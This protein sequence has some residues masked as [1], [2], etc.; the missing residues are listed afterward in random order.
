MDS[1]V[2][3][4]MVKMSEL[5]KSREDK[6]TA[7]SCVIYGDGSC[8]PNPGPSG[9]GVHGMDSDGHTFNAWGGLSLKSSNNRG[10]LA[11]YI[12]ILEMTL[13]YKW[14]NTVIHL[15][16][17]YVINGAMR[18]ITKWKK[19]GW[20]KSDGNVIS[21]KDLWILIDTLQS[22][23]AKAKQVID[24]K[25][26][27]AHTGVHGNEMADANADKGRLS[28]V[29]G[30]TAYFLHID[31]DIPMAEIKEVV[32]AS[33][34]KSTK[35]PGCNRLIAGK[36]LYFTTNSDMM[37]PDN[38]HIYMTNSFDD[39]TEW[40]GKLCGQLSSD[41]LHG[42]I[43]TKKAVEPL[44]VLIEYQNMITPDDFV[45]PV[46]GM[47]DRITKPV[48]WSMLNTLGYSQLVHN[49]Y[50]ILTVDK[51]PLTLYVRP[52]R[53]AYSTMDIL[54]VML[55]R[56]DTY[57][58]DK[59]ANGVEYIDITDNLYSKV[60]KVWKIHTGKGKAL[61]FFKVP[62][63]HNGKS[64]EVILTMG[65]DILPRNN[66][67]GL[68]KQAESLNVILVKYNNSSASF[69]YSVIFKTESDIA[70]YMT[71]GANLKIS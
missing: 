33:K 4:M 7:K 57:R 54:S 3:G 48:N 15:D 18:F 35:L 2:E 59:I 21:N 5:L 40:K 65:V 61:K 39:K 12:F 70:I 60:G 50:N 46:I 1:I 26:V 68:G 71:S 19:N 38:Y 23:I 9:W 62:V 58:F 43:L 25:W 17:K 66:L 52:P 55:D 20:T 64:R 42:V 34:R 53:R 37:T 27:K 16:S 36:R 45:Q 56:L 13:H 67:I 41:N 14:K 32:K 29:K 44:E 10:E 49:R 22:K 31:T 11:A 28:I 30:E 8:N 47:L 24:V 63:T 51:E 69:R 6:F